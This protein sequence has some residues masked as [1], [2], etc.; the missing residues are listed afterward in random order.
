MNPS[1]RSPRR[2]FSLVEVAVASVL[3]GIIAVAAISSFALL[4][5]QL[6]R[7]QAE[8]RASDDAKSLIDFVVGDL[9]SVGGGAVRPWMALWVEDGADPVSATRCAQF[10]GCGASDRL[11]MA[12]VVP[13]SRTCPILSMTTTDI[14]T[15]GSGDECCFVKLRAEG[16]GY[17]DPPLPSPSPPAL[18]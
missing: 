4:N 13:D 17:F 12:L 6:V 9:Q 11:T 3:V 1:H 10:T 2:A 18:P 7:L 16:G 8:T 14:S 5:R 15:S